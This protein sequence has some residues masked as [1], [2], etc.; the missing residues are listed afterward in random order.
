MRKVSLRAI[1]D[2]ERQEYG[3]L[4][5]EIV[6]SYYDDI[7]PA[8]A[9]AN[10]ETHDSGTPAGA[11][12]T[13]A[14]E[15]LTILGP[16]STPVGF[17][18]LTYKLGGSVK[19]GPTIL[20]PAFRGQGY[21]Q[22]V[23]RALEERARAKRARKLYATAPDSSER[24]VS[25]LLRAGYTVE[26]HLDRQ[27][28]SAHG[29]IVFGKMLDRRRFR[30]L[31]Q[32]A[33]TRERARVAAPDALDRNLVVAFVADQFSRNWLHVTRHFASDL[34]ENAM[35]GSHV[36]YED[37]PKELI[38][39]AHHNKPIAAAIL[40]PKR[41]GAVKSFFFSTSRHKQTLHSL[42]GAAHRSC[43]RRR[44]R[45]LFV[46]HGIGDREMIDALA[47]KGFE[48]EGILREPYRSGEDAIV[49]SRFV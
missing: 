23:R 41:G 35:R 5:T 8:F 34:I 17:T 7:S 29:E 25:Y 39:L 43:V 6:G 1:A 15:V 19:S 2:G 3:R 26:A 46:V 38:I 49:L 24:V 44:A 47:S 27:Y 45:K 12:M 36:T 22:A 18:T 42:F 37:R 9:L 33:R 10:L 21:G 40:I 30:P 20:F 28:S 31:Q 13:S 48:P 4:V 32:P 14:K 16:R 11:F